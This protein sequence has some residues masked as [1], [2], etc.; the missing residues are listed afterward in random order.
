MNPKDFL[1]PNEKNN[2][3]LRLP[4]GGSTV[5]T[6]K[7]GILAAHGVVVI[8]SLKVHPNQRGNGYGFAVV[9]AALGIIRDRWPKTPIYVHALPYGDDTLPQ[10]KLK[11]FYR[12]LGF[13]DTPGHPFEMTHPPYEKEKR[14]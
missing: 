3:E 11:A 14:T 4:I 2:W 10:S 13:T 1:F 8:H 12:K 7:V 5:E 6:A 9:F